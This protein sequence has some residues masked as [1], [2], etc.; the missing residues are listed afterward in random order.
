[1]ALT[2]GIKVGPDGLY[3]LSK[4]IEQE[5]SQLVSRD[6]SLLK[7]NG[8]TINIEDLCE[9]P[10]GY[11]KVKCGL[12]FDLF[13]HPDINSKKLIVFLNGTRTSNVPEFKRWSYYSQVQANVLN[14]ADPM[15]RLFENINLGWY[16]GTD[17]IDVRNNTAIIIKRV[18]ELLG[19]PEL[20]IC[21]S[22]GG[23][24]AAVHLAH[25]IGDCNTILI[26]PQLKLSL[27]KFA[28]V[29]SKKTGNNLNS[30]DVRN[31]VVGLLGA[32]CSV[33]TL[34]ISNLSSEDDLPQLKHV[35][36]EKNLTV[37]YGYNRYDNLIIW[38]YDAPGKIAHNNQEFFPLFNIFLKTV[39]ETIFSM[40][41]PDIFWY[42]SEFWHDHYKLTEKINKIETK[43]D[44]FSL[45]TV[46]ATV[47]KKHVVLEPS[48]DPWHHYKIVSPMKSGE[49]YHLTVMETKKTDES[50]GFV[51]VVKDVK[52]DKILFRTVSKDSIV[53]CF[54]HSK[55]YEQGCE[56][57][58]YPGSIGKP[59]LHFIEVDYTIVIHN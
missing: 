29:F 31:D 56:I 30:N 16:Y 27:Y 8:V 41:E 55:E 20:V 42:I 1:M 19:Y 59:N 58:L 21:A 45:A 22:S 2:N 48:R 33:K 32:N 34:L 5:R 36:E 10:L 46:N 26:N 28:D 52:N 7:D 35:L 6:Y 51:V 57:R 43:K 25:I 47:V 40:S 15:Y 24:S 49:L 23:G 44:F 54:I 4:I 11:F 9:L 13:F 12:T 14:I 53:E 18:R 17:K 50:T 3:S 37:S 38:T 39:D